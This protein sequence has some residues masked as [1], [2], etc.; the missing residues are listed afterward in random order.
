MLAPYNTYYGIRFELPLYEPAKRFDSFCAYY[1]HGKTDWADLIADY[2][3]VY[4]ILWDIFED[5]IANGKYEQVS[6]IE[7]LIL[8]NKKELEFLEN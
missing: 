6:L 5:Y 4:D 3:K 1:K 8:K 7:K 2:P